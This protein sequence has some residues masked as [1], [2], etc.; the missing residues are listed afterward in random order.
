MR[1]FNIILLS[2]AILA[3]TPSLVLAQSVTV[4]GPSTVEVGIA[5]TFTVKFSNGGD[6]SVHVVSYEWSAPFIGNGISGPSGIV[7]SI[8]GNT[9]NNPQT[10]A[11]S[12]DS[13]SV[14][15]IWGDFFDNTFDKVYVTVN[16]KKG[17]DNIKVDKNV[18]VT[19]KRVC[20]PTFSG[21][22]S[23]QK[24]CTTPVTFTA[25]A[26]D[27][28][29]FTW[30]ITSGGTI[31]SGNGTNTIT[32]TPSVSDGFTITCV[33]RRSSGLTAY[34]RTNTTTITRFQPIT[35]AITAPS[36]FCSGSTYTINVASLCGMT[37]V[38]WTPPPSLLIVSGQGTQTVVVTPA[39]GVPGGT[40]GTITAQA[41]M[42]GGCTAT[43]SQHNFTIYGAETPPAP[44]GYITLELESGDACHDPVYR[45]V[46]HTN[47]PYLNGYTSVSPGIVLGGTHPHGGGGTSDQI[48]IRVCNVNRCSG[49]SSCIEF[50][51]DRPY[52]CGGDG[53]A[54]PQTGDGGGEGSPPIVTEER[55]GR[56]TGIN[57]Q[58]I[59][60][61]PNP[62]T[63][64]IFYLSCP[65]G[66]SGR[67]ILFDCTGKLVGRRPFEASD[68]A[69]PL[70]GSP[71]QKGVYFLQITA[72]N[73]T[74][75][76]KIVVQ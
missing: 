44:Q 19:V 17:G 66:I 2:L 58:E 74:F 3:L 67:A 46:W 14:P 64:G 37:G 27:A 26:C 22:T 56:G 68:H 20:T 71:L 12:S 52:P 13:S 51:I 31:T 32:V 6:T 25:S 48:K 60:V 75:T 4:T 45:V 57:L 7:G 47:F 76:Q 18:D 54:A 16:Y 23:I 53:L 42:V 15:I 70:F 10:I 29:S 65:A 62:T 1:R 40:T 39:S 9:T 50:W 8:N 49:I 61:Y 28:N 69:T 41:V 73:E 72:A 5:G 59:S 36:F 24:C 43:V 34:S 11:S 63:S 55:N 38:T 35:P 21:P 30:S 33:A